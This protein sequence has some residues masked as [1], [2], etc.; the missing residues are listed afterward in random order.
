M[1]PDTEQPVEKY[2]AGPGKTLGGRAGERLHPKMSGERT[3][4][5]AHREGRVPCV[6][7][8]ALGLEGRCC[9]KVRDSQSSS[10]PYLKHGKS[11]KTISSTG[12]LV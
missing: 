12:N 2:K 1:V 6:Q 7:V 11:T 5:A 9:G 3:Q 8:P 4:A 10:H